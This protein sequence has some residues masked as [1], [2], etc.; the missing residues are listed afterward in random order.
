[1]RRSQEQLRPLGARE[2]AGLRQRAIQELQ[3]RLV[4][5]ALVQ[6]VEGGPE[7]RLGAFRLSALEKVL[8]EGHDI[9]PVGRAA[10]QRVAQRGVVLL[11]QDLRES[12]I[13][14]LVHLVV[15]EDEPAPRRTDEPVSLLDPRKP[16]ER[17][18]ARRTDRLRDERRVEVEPAAGGDVEDLAL[19]VPERGDARRDQLRDRGGDLDL[20]DDLR[21]DPHSV[22]ALRQEPALAQTPD[23][24]EDEERVAVRLRGDLEAEFLRQPLRAKGVHEQLREILGAE[25]REREA[26][27]VGQPL[28]TGG[29]LPRHAPPHRPDQEHAV[30]GHGHGQCGEEGEPLGRGEV[31]VVDQE[32]RGA[33]FRQRARRLDEDRLQRVLVE[34]LLSVRCRLAPQ[35]RGEGGGE[36]RRLGQ[37]LGQWL[38]AEMRAVGG[39]ERARLGRGPAGRVGAEEEVHGGAQPAGELV[40]EPCLADPRLAFHQQDLAVAR[41]RALVERLQPRQVVVAAVERGLPRD[42]HAP[43]GPLRALADERRPMR[44]PRGLLALLQHLQEHA[45]RVEP[46]RRL[47]RHERR[48]DLLEEG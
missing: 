18:N 46:L 17:G 47:P 41:R 21:G 36:Q 40:H 25:P 3:S 48:E 39:R 45:G 37:V 2:Q 20:L 9:A 15:V 38:V 27:R 19:L 32:D 6:V 11:A 16:A 5:V 35:Q 24:L 4:Q 23:D 22:V 8:A 44:P 12:R 13:E 28:E 31:Q 34:R 42:A 26:R 30:A 10:L 14:R 29:P 33:L 1:L 7:V 43:Q